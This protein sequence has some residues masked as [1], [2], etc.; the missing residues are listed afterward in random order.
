M[1]V[2][3]PFGIEF[4]RGGQSGYEHTNII[5][6]V[7]LRQYSASYT[8]STDDVKYL[9]INRFY[10]G[11]LGAYPFRF[12]DWSDHK[13]GDA[14]GVGRVMNVDGVI[15]LVKFYGDSIRPFIRLIQKPIQGVVITGMT[16]NPVVNLTNGVVTGATISG[17]AA[18]GLWQGEFNVPVRFNEPPSAR[19][20]P[21][22]NGTLAL[23]WGFSLMEKI[24][25]P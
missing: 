15:R 16:G 7:P 12:Y 13:S 20:T 3:P 4:S 24:L 10:L 25:S 8:S 17:G 9:A 21:R 23:E 1:T 11:R 6:D 22:T 18:Y 14:G 19:F 2:S 5:R